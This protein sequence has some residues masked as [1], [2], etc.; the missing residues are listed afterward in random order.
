MSEVVEKRRTYESGNMVSAYN[1]DNPGNIDNIKNIINDIRDKNL[2]SLECYLYGLVDG[3]P[4][5]LYKTN[6]IEDLNGYLNEN[7]YKDIFV[8]DICNDDVDYKFI[9]ASGELRISQKS[10]LEKGKSL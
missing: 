9:P 1:I 6:N 8:M 2:K 10:S 4:K 3:K 5:L 7:T